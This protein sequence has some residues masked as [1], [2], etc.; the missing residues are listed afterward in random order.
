MSE[1][2]LSTLAPRSVERPRCPRCQAPALVQRRFP[3]RSGFEHWTLRCP[4]CGNIHE[5]QVQADPMT[6]ELAGWLFGDL[7]AP[8]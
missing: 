7:H 5:T 3:G 2:Q 6:S 8:T 1:L 4:K